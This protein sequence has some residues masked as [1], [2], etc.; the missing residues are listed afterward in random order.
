M[1]INRYG[2]TY[3][4]GILVTKFRVSY[5]KLTSTVGKG[6]LGDPHLTHMIASSVP[7]RRELLF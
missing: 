2:R 4:N 1:N 5:V 7:S 3:R 6:I